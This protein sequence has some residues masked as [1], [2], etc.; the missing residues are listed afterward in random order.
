MNGPDDVE[1]LVN[2]E[3][4]CAAWD[5]CPV[6]VGDAGPCQEIVGFLG[7]DQSQLRCVLGAAQ[8]CDGNVFNDLN[9]CFDNGGENPIETDCAALCDAQQLCAPDGFELRECVTACEGRVNFDSPDDLVRVRPYLDCVESRSCAELNAC[10]ESSTPEAICQA[11]CARADEC[12]AAGPVADCL[13]RCN[14][15]FAREREIARR[16]CLVDAADCDAVTACEPPQPLPCEEACRVQ[17]TCFGAFPGQADQC[18]DQCEDQGFLAPVRTARRIICLERAGEDCDAVFEC[19]DNPQPQPDACLAYCRATSDECQENPSNEL[20]GCIGACLNGFGDANGLIFGAAEACL[21]ELPAEADCAALTACLP[22]EAPAVD[23]AAFC[24]DVDACRAGGDDCA[25]R[26]AASPDRDQAGCVAEAN[27]T[28]RRCTAIAACVGFE[29]P[30]ADETA[31]ALCAQ[32]SR[33]DAA[34]DPFICRMDTTPTPPAAAYQRACLEVSSCD[35]VEACTALEAA[36]AA[37][38]ADLCADAVACGRFPDEASCLAGCTGM[39]ASPT[40]DDDF[41]AEGAQC[42]EDARGEE[43][44]DEGAAALCLNVASCEQPNPLSLIGPNG[45]RLE[46]DIQNAPNNYGGSCG[47]DDAAE[48]VVALT[49]NA[50]AR[51]RIAVVQADYDPLMYVRSSCDD[52]RAELG[53]NDDFDQLLPRVDIDADAGTYY[54]FIEGWNGDTGRGVLEVDVDPI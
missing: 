48:A 49:L 6:L 46:F 21:G 24:E 25:A 16:E 1:E 33:C 42:L 28:G 39:N 13:A 8:R 45:G 3:Q 26:C 14:E 29:P 40:T 12:G 23:C 11:Q 18:V 53:C 19:Q 10:L 35:A 20:G 36:P 5:A 7:D 32:L 51:V 34:I 22:A 43:M 15:D 47:A 2:I 38:C 9:Q 41:I 54:I 44:C 50:P 27:R 37:G 4:V 30:E 52:A 31:R 17:A